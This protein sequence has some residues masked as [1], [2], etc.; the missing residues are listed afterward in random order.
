MPR[1]EIAPL[2]EARLFLVE[3]DEAR[4]RRYMEASHVEP[5]VVFES[6]DGLLLA[7]GY[8]RVEAAR[9]RGETT[10]E[11]EIRPGG[12][13]GAMRYAGRERA[14]RHEP[15]AHRE[16]IVR[17]RTTIGLPVDDAVIARLLD[18]WRLG[19]DVYETDEEAARIAPHA[20]A[21]DAAMPRLRAYADAHPESFAG[22]WREH[23]DGAPYVCIAF[24]GDLRAHRDALETDRVRV[25]PAS[26]TAAELETIADAIEP[27]TLEPVGA[28]VNSVGIDVQAGVVCVGADGPDEAAARA[29]LA[30]R[31]GDAVRLEWNVGPAIAC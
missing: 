25:R 24:T 1:L 29:L 30:A 12:H 17:F 18:D 14:F 4:V 9:R 10:I 8:H 5:V 7:D 2:L 20:A 31:Y 23:E 28:Q 21:V 6:A 13:R 3:L 19:L 26:R 15:E 27:D 22:A 11:A 16:D